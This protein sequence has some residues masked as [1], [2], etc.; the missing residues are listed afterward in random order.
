MIEAWQ[1]GLPVVTTYYP[2]L[3]EI[4][5]ELPDEKLFRVAAGTPQALAQEIEHTEVAPA[6][7]QAA[8]YYGLNYFSAS[9]MCCRWEE[10]LIECVTEFRDASIYGRIQY[11]N[12]D[13]TEPTPFDTSGPSPRTPVEQNLGWPPKESI[14]IPPEL[15]PR[16]SPVIIP[17][18]DFIGHQPEDQQFKEFMTPEELMDVQKGFE[19][20]VGV[21]PGVSV[22]NPTPEEMSAEPPE[23]NELSDL[24][25]DKPPEPKPIDVD[26]ARL[27][28]DP[29]ERIHELDGG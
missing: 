6:P 26:I 4:Q 10:Y 23:S 5:A 20:M 22:R 16:G 12:P 29:N 14:G 13:T 15:D 1:A 28:I 2:T 17:P 9:S 21:L 24:V 18:E 3:D 11:A 19:Q 27:G 25:P 7:V 8:Q